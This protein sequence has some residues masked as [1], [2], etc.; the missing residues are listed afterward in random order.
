MLEILWTINAAEI[1]FASTAK[2]LKTQVFQDWINF[3]AAFLQ[4]AARTGELRS[5]MVFTKNVRHSK[6]FA[7]NLCAIHMG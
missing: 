6:F 1:N 5:E 7:Q 3:S 4:I 2:P